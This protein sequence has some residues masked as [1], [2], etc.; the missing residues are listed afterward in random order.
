[1]HFLGRMKLELDQGVGYRQAVQNTMESV[2]RA[3]IYTSVVFFS[4]FGLFLFSQFQP[5]RGF[6]GQVSFTV[7]G[8]LLADI[9]LLPG[10]IMLVRPF[11]TKVREARMTGADLTSAE[12]SAASFVPKT[13]S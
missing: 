3:L 8:A 5:I 2:G 13:S 9:L 12:E 6:G 11:K 10:L 7:I 1:M 4:G